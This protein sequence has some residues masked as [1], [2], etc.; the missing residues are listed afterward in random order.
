MS[1]YSDLDPSIAEM[2]SN[3]KDTADESEDIDL[4]EFESAGE[5][6]FSMED[7]ARRS[8]L[9]DSKADSVKKKTKSIHE[10]DLSQHEFEPVEQ[11]LSDEA[12]S[13]FEDKSYYKTALT[14]E[15]ASSQRVH[16]LLSKYLTCQDPKDR[17]VYR[18]NLIS[19]YWELLR[20]MAPKMADINL[21]MPK[22]MMCRFGVLLP[23]LFRPEQKTFFSRIFFENRP[24]EPVMYVDEWFKEIAA[25]RM[26]NS[27]TDEKRTPV[28][29]ANAEEAARI[30]QT[31]LMQLKSKNSGKLQSAENLLNIKENER[32]MLET[33]L[34]AKVDQLCEHNP[35]LGF[36]PHLCEYDEMQL[37]LFS[38]ISDR[39]HRLSK[40]NKELS[41]CLREFQD[42]KG[43]YT[44]VENKL[45][46]GPDISAATDSN[47][48]N[49]DSPPDGK[50]DC[51]TAGKSV[52][53]FYA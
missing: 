1:D 16:Q 19:A 48:V 27:M 43:V 28:K 23:S 10:V 51:R 32:A 50:N 21:P 45:A 17:T 22:R 13:V 3:V 9:F 2:L 24:C 40:N 36:E 49:I 4:S 33:E 31:R 39:L 46:G 29:A 14:N 15:N 18:Q 5:K 6:K 53:D 38:E 41:R 26:S 8:K 47:A 35:V 25:G 12:S 42:A 30:E 11:M 7:F 37:K 52:S 34:K 20:G 44:S